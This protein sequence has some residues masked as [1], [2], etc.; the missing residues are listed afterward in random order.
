MIDSS[1]ADL[2][3]SQQCPLF[4]CALRIYVSHDTQLRTTLGRSSLACE[5]GD[6]SWTTQLPT[7]LICPNKASVFHLVILRAPVST[8]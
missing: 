6:G 7:T 8:L 4:Y 3:Y 1:L 2:Q 5:G